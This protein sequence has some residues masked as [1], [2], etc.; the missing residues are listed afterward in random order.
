MQ[1][2][3][4]S[5]ISD[6]VG[7]FFYLIN[8]RYESRQALFLPGKKARTFD[9]DAIFEQTRR[10]AIERSQRIL[11]TFISKH[12]MT[13]CLPIH[14]TVIVASLEERQKETRMEEEGEG[15]KPVKSSVQ[16]ERHKATAAT[17][18]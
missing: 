13:G 4:N 17:L 14:V 1:S 5:Q 16:T 11:G 2:S 3:V 15:S 9:L 8:W 6:M 7:L 10:T 18:R 12:D